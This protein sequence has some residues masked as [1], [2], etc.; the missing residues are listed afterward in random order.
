MRKKEEK[1]LKNDENED[2]VMKKSRK[3]VE[4]AKSPKKTKVFFF[5]RKIL[6]DFHGLPLLLLL[7]L[8]SAKSSTNSMILFSECVIP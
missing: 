7:L 6:Y 2:F 8:C 3:H 5:T 1:T 4:N